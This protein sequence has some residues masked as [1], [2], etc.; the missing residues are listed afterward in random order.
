MTK[1]L[2]YDFVFNYFK[3]HGCKLLSKEYINNRTPMDYICSCGNQDIITFDS[4]K[5][6]SRCRKCKAEK[7]SSKNKKYS[8]EDVKHYI[9]K[10]GYILLS[11]E[12]INF[13][14]H[15]IVQCPEGHEP[16]PVTWDNFKRGRRCPE[17]AK[18]IRANSRRLSFKKIEK[19][20]STCEGYE[21]LSTNYENNITPLT[22]KCPEGHIFEMD[23]AHFSRG[24]RC[25]ECNPTKKKTYKEIKEYIESFN[26]YKLLSN[27]YI[28]NQEKLEIQCPEG[29]VFLMNYASFKAGDRCP[30]CAGC[31][32]K[33]IEEVK[34]YIRQYD[35][36]LLSDTYVNA[37]N[38]LLVKCPQNH[39]YEVN[40]NN[41]QS[42]KRC[43]ICNESKG[44]QKISEYLTSVNIN[45]HKQYSF[46]D[47]R[48]IEPLRF[49]FAIFDNFGNI[50]FMC[51]YDGEYH[52]QP[53]DGQKKLKYQQ[54][55]DNIKNTYCQKNN[56]SL[57]RIPYWDFDHIEKILSEQL[58][59]HKLVA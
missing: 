38:K 58:I 33:T 22:F 57:L 16:Y 40:W 19:Y 8:F 15:L 48:N 42:G 32:K 21:L 31:M 52:Y 11:K 1:R 3:E 20:M 25:T 14:T 46:D 17:C 18:I 28:N 6:G 34:Q 44:E 53:I 5:R 13:S 37:Q 51:E 9:E 30:Y 49:D 4:F 59:K 36:T 26:G 23:W 24:Q 50:S 56:I 29:H 47:C 12:Y 10:E 41:F 55:L 43:P 7:I 45:F 35:Y 39:I 27:E 2:T 54:K